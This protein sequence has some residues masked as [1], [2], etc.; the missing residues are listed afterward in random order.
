MTV[1]KIKMAHSPDTTEAVLDKV[2]S[3]IREW[4]GTGKYGSIQ[5]NFKDG[6]ILTLDLRES[7]RVVI[8]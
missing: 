4:M 8:K 5:I 6:D 7:V 2:Q 3:L 1:Y